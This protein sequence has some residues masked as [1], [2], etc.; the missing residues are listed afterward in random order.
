MATGQV[1]TSARVGSGPHAKVAH[2]GAVLAIHGSLTVQ[3]QQA[4]ADDLQMFHGPKPVWGFLSSLS[5]EGFDEPTSGL[6]QPFD[7]SGH[8]FHGSTL[9]LATHRETD[10]FLLDKKRL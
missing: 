6:F 2:R 7:R 10:A 4:R 1:H 5:T 8:S 9:T 3:H